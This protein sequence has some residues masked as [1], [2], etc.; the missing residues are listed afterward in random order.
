MYNMK[1]DR[2]LKNGP[3]NKKKTIPSN[4][5][6]EMSLDLSKILRKRAMN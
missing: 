4:V 1:I 2:V 5:S 6:S 3:K